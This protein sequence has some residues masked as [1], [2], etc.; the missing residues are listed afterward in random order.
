MEIF[1][2]NP[3]R[4]WLLLLL[5]LLNVFP[6]G[7]II[8]YVTSADIIVFLFFS[9]WLEAHVGVSIYLF[10]AAVFIVLANLISLSRAGKAGQTPENTDLGLKRKTHKIRQTPQL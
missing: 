2:W 8:H 3:S 7:F 1:T 6:C 9:F 5:F 10:V 4:H